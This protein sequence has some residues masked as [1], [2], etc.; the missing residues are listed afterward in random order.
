MFIPR[1]YQPVPLQEG[2]TV[3][4]NES[5]S[6]H[7]ANVLRIKVGDRIVMF[8]GEGGEYAA[9]VIAVKRK[10]VEVEIDVFTPREVESP[11]RIELAQSIARGEKMDLIVQ[12]A[13]E[14]GVAGITPIITARTTVRLNGKR[15][16]KRL[17][18]WQQVAVSAC[19]QC[20]RNQLPWVDAPVSLQKWLSKEKQADY[21]FVLSPNMGEPAP[22]E[23]APGSSVSILVGPESGLDEE[24]IAFA[25]GRGFHPLNLG[26]RVL[27]TET[28][29][30]AAI[31]ALQCRYGDM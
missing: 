5:A 24:E 14:L 1:I 13:V 12:K 22:V 25:L 26:P 6:H 19:E 18:H 11:I 20:G 3:T 23:I 16:E 4:L 27:R 10:L 7:L 30:L 8:N 15:E 29:G 17:D 2:I 21:R 31:T 28:A 9:H